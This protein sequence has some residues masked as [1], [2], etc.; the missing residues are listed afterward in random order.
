MG[1]FLIF[2]GNV[3][4]FILSI[5]LRLALYSA[6]L[7][8]ALIKV[9]A[10]F[11]TTKAI[12]A[13][14]SKKSNGL[15][16]SSS[17]VAYISLKSLVALLNLLIIVVDIIL[18][19]LTT[20]GL[21]LGFVVS[22]L[23]LTV[24]VAGAYIIILNDCSVG[25]SSNRG[26]ADQ[27]QV[28]K[29]NGKVGSS[30]TAGMGKLTEEAKNWAK[31]WQVTYI[32][33]SLGAGSE[34]NFKSA[35][36]NAEY[37]SDPSRG[38]ISIRGQRTGE[39]AIAT[40]KRLV[41]EGKVKDNLVVAIGTNNDMSTSAMQQFYDAIPSN[42]KTITW[43]LTA[44]EGGVNNSFINATIK[45][46]V[47]SHDNM[48]YLDW[49][50]YVDNNGGWS[51]YQGGD[52]IH[53]SVSGYERYV[54]F[55]TQGL[56]DL[57]GSGGKSAS[58]VAAGGGDFLEKLYGVAQNTVST[59]IDRHVQAEE[60]KKNNKTGCNFTTSK[61]SD[62]SNKSDKG[63]S[64]I[65]GNL[66]PDGTGSVGSLSGS[67]T[68]SELPNELKKY[69]IDPESVGVKYG[70][71][72]QEAIA[73]PNSGGWIDFIGSPWSGQCTELSATLLYQL[74]EK[75]GQHFSNAQGNGDQV[76]GIVASK[77]GIST[78]NSP[79]TGSIFSASYQH[80]GV[81][82]HVF[83]NGDI[84]IIEQNTPKSGNSIG[85]PNTWNYRIIT[86]ASFGTECGN[87]FVSPA[88]AGYKLVGNVKSVG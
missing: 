20:L 68:P 45:N 9:P 59:A 64:T 87:G 52:N 28:A 57:Y 85:K 33:D 48:R 79:K 49:K 10:N 13:V 56:Y 25:S 81:V 30:E 76:A 44:S 54:N 12:K 62:G 74:W 61:V 29:S 17:L 15:I 73:A 51:S 32:G 63:T 2:I 18:F 3:L 53:M 24:I 19:F 43:V 72:W 16:K 36:P 60:D 69:A 8:L 80:V 5:L 82:S 38:L 31:G 7:S 26:T 40:L 41:S 88:D 27:T 42:V 78:T 47:N 71:A 21:L 77:L 66:Q 14:N 11:T 55:Q 23:I 6:R 70:A 4:V 50:T 83:E 1:V 67:F 46:F 39:T 65:G 35:F 58:G 22:L 37:H 75:G 86:K 34:A 84:L